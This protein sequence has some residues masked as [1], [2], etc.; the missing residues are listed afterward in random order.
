MDPYDIHIIPL[1]IF[2]TQFIP[3]GIHNLSKWFLQILDTV[4]NAKKR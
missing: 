2:E 4:Y 1:N 3:I